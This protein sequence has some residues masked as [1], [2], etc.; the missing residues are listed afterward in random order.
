M[1]LKKFSITNPYEL[2]VA[3]QK[4]KILKE[5]IFNLKASTPVDTGEARDGWKLEK[6]KIVNSVTHIKSL[7]EGSSLQAPSYFIEMALLR[8]QGV[9]PNGNIVVEVD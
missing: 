2:L 5:A 6:N 7:N 9:L 4:N 1:I 8:T 3:K